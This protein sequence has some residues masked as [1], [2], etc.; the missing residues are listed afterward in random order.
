MKAEH[1]DAAE[2]VA[3]LLVGD[4]RRSPPRAGCDRARSVR[5]VPRRHRRSRA[6][7]ARAS[8]AAA[9]ARTTASRA[10][11]RARVR[12]RRVRATSG[13]RSRSRSSEALSSSSEPA[14]ARSADIDS[15][16]P[17][18]STSCEVARQ[19]APRWRER[20]RVTAAVTFGLPSRSPPTQVPQRRN[21][22]SRHVAAE[23]AREP[24]LERAIHP[25]R[26]LEQ[27]AAKHVERGLDLVERRRPAHARILGGVQREHLGIER[28]R[29]RARSRRRGSPPIRRQ[30]IERRCA[31]ATRSGAR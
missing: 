25:R 27:R 8:R 7:R 2:R 15:E 9:P 14:R 21:V 29:S 13:S 20:A 28:D 18:F 24:I 12:G 31:A 5:A 26:D 1:V 10:T 22:G 4:L 17:S 23:R 6:R 3:Q 16:R 30:V 19:H 11:A